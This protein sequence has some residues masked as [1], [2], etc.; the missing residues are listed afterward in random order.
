M[1]RTWIIILVVVLAIIILPIM[2]LAGSYNDL[3]A[4]DEEVNGSWAQVENQLKRRADLIPNLVKTVQGFAD[5]EKDVLIGVTE[6]RSK[7]MKADSPEEFANANNQLTSALQGLNV[8]VERYP[9]L[10]SN[11]N[12]IQL[13]DEL[14][15]TENRIAVSRK[16]YNDSAKILNSKIRRFPTNIVAGIFGIDKREYFEVSEEDTEVPDVEFE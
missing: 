10:K 11:E 14:A 1:K 16:D 12:F 8:V 13:Q 4:L 3:V 2:L 9:E 7:V 15:G 5:Q 6:A